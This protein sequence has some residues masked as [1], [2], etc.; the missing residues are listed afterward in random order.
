MIIDYLAPG[1][2]TDIET[3]LCIVGSGAA[4][5][6]IAHT[7]AGS[8]I[9]VCVL[10]SGG[11]GG[12]Y[13]TQSLN[14]GKS[15]G[16]AELDPAT[17]RMRAFGGSCNLWGGGCVPLTPQDF[18]ARSW[19]PESGWPLSFDAMTPYY[20]RA[21]SFCGVDV[22]RLKEGK[23]ES[24]LA[25]PATKVDG[26]D[27]ANQLC[28][29]TPLKFG[30]AYRE[31]MERSHNVTVLLHC[32]LLELVPSPCGTRVHEARI[33]ALDGRRGILK[34]KQFVLACG[35]IENARVLLL[36]NS[37]S[38]KGIG[39][40]H[41]LVGRYFMDHP[42]VKLGSLAIQLPDLFARYCS[43]YTKSPTFLTYP[44]ISLADD[45]QHRHQTLNCRVRAIAVEAEVPRSIKAI[46]HFR[47]ADKSSA[48]EDERVGSRIQNALSLK[49]AETRD[50][51]PACKNGVERRLR[52]LVLDVGS[53][54]RAIGRKMAGLSTVKIDHFELF[55][56]FEQAPNP[57][58]RITLG[59]E[60]D[61]LGQRK[62]HVDWRFTD[63][64]THTYRSAAKLFGE[65]LAKRFGGRYR[66]E[67]WVSGEGPCEARHIRGAAHHL[68]T[69]R[70]SA[71]PVAGVVD[72]DC[73]VHGLNNLYIAGSSVFPSGGWAFPTL[74][75]IALSLRLADHLQ[76]RFRTR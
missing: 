13:K 7:F 31:E 9:R 34:A 2:S 19:V 36:S 24:P 57:K 54:S 48:N 11:L 35:G 51:S 50:S 21:L 62:V 55:G 58:S 16:G 65:S 67:E 52:D 63:L 29:L 17:S 5:L 28:A 41:D 59:E 60:T 4:G 37:L 44:E 30:Q 61:A 68:G 56:F 26:G 45:S 76:K 64:D 32:N 73:L 49:R 8:D 75:I 3:D 46:R 23:A 70:M 27:L 1:S 39:N 74:T 42:I 14:E 53:V 25:L 18:E 66:P 43:S 10:E 38:P 20:L 22:G 33:G 6:S 47:A 40:E 12:E 72:V 69:T 15:I 71:T